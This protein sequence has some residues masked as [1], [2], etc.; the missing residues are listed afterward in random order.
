MS[1][2]PVVSVVSAAPVLPDAQ[3]ITLSPRI[4]ERFRDFV[5]HQ[6]RRSVD[7][8]AIPEPVRQPSAAKP[9]IQI[10]PERRRPASDEV[11]SRFANDISTGKH[12]LPRELAK[13]WHV[14]ITTIY[15]WF[16]QEPDV[17]A[18]GNR[19][20]TRHRRR[21]RSMRIPEAVAVRV[22]RRMCGRA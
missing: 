12:Y 20:D 3:Q 21:Y 10:R 17:V 2:V 11:A 19:T 6:S 14:S 4:S 1:S 9:V 7:L 5:L 16:D 15:E 13:M 22:H 8:S 18:W